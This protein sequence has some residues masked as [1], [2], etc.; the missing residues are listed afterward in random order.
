M[1]NLVKLM[2]VVEV[3]M[4]QIAITVVL[5]AIIIKVILNYW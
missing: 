1:I 5:P 3:V 2:A 4:T